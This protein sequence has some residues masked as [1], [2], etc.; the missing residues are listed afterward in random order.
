MGGVKNQEHNCCKKVTR[1]EETEGEPD[2]SEGGFLGEG[3]CQSEERCG[4]GKCSSCPSKDGGLDPARENG[5][6]R[7]GNLQPTGAQMNKQLKQNLLLFL[8]KI[9]SSYRCVVQFSVSLWK[10]S[11]C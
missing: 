4:G 1:G 10:Q 8:S 7:S 11:P 2:C 6:V 5:Q 3:E 9:C